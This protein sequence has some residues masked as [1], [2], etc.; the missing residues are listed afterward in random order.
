MQCHHKPWWPSGYGVRTMELGCIWQ[1]QTENTKVWAPI[2]ALLTQIS[3]FSHNLQVSNLFPFPI[4]LNWTNLILRKPAKE[5]V[6]CLGLMKRISL[7][8]I[9]KEI[10]MFLCSQMTFSLNNRV[11]H[12]IKSVSTYHFSFSGQYLDFQAKF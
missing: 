7:V 11:L 8:S 3:H 10:M 4:V 1:G 2:E 12:E 9:P 6:V 5:L